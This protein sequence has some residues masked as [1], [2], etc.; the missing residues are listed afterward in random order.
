[1]SAWK[2]DALAHDL[3]QHLRESSARMVWE[4]MQLGPSGSPRPDVF[5]L[6]KSFTRPMPTTYEI[7]ISRS[8]FLADCNAAKWQKYL[9]FSAGVIFAVPEGLISKAE[10][11]AG[12][13]L[14][15]RYESGWR[16]VKAPRWGRY[17]LG[18][19]VCMKLL[20]DGRSRVG[21]VIKQR[22]ASEYHAE[23]TLRR[24]LGKDVAE[25]VRG[26]VHAKRML[27]YYQAEQ[28]KA[29][30]EL[31]A[32]KVEARTIRQQAKEQGQREGEQ[33]A[34]VALHRLCGALGVPA[35]TSVRMIAV[36]IDRAAN[37]LN[38]DAVVRGLENTIESIRHALD[39]SETLRM[40]PAP[41][42]GRA[43]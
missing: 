19:D 38:R 35:D 20:I 27:E 26:G 6:A 37:K 3:A 22:S 18:G 21:T 29:R 10:V 40:K 7:K 2:H 23:E 24:K 33:A 32:L 4:D 39:H 31:D 16:T 43:R 11:P 1:M 9:A 17:D 30:R 41:K 34:R 36:A 13:G 15:V 5:T 42:K 14:I 25:F 28:E 8:D 12:C